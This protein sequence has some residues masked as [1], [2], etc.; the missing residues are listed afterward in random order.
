VP[1][2]VEAASPTPAESPAPLVVVASTPAASGSMVVIVAPKPAQPIDKGLPGPGLLAFVITS[3]YCDHLPLNRQEAI[4]GRLGVDI[5]RSTLCGWM[6]AS[7]DLLRPLYDAMLADILRSRVVQTDETRLPV[8]E[9][10]SDKTKSGRLWAFVGDR[11]HPHIAY[12]YTET[13]A[14]DGPASIVKDYKRSRA[15]A[16]STTLNATPRRSLTNKSSMAS[17]R[18]LCA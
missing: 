13:K 9:K 6:A 16:S 14:R 2:P 8:L 3:K 4:I 11:D 15:S 12:H 1:A 18:T 5:P 7:A 10:G 17:R